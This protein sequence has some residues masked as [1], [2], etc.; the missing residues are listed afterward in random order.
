MQ[1]H[2]SREAL[3]IQTILSPFRRGIYILVCLCISSLV[4]SAAD[5]GSFVSGVP[6]PTN[7]PLVANGRSAPIIASD[8]DYPGVLRAVASLQEDIFRVTG[9]RPSY[10]NN[11]NTLQS[12]VVIIGTIGKNAII[13]GL[14]K[15]KKLN[16]SAVS[17]KWE[18]SVTQVINNPLP[19]VAK[20]LVIAGSDKRGTIFGIYTLS[21][22]IGVSPWYWWADVPVKTQ[23][24]LFVDAGSHVLNEP[25]VKYRGIFLNDEAPALS[26]WAKEKFG[27]L[28]H[29]FYEKVFELLLRLKGNYLWPAMWGNAFNDDDKLNPALADEYGIVMG[30]SHHEPMQRAQ[31]EWKRYGKGEWNYQNN[32]TT[33]RSFWRQGIRNM[34]KHES[35]VT[36]G[37]RG[38]GDEPMSESSNIKLLEK[39]V[40]DQREI[41]S[42]VTGKSSTETPQLWAL[43]KEVQDYYDKGMRV[44]GDIT[45]L[46]CDDNWGNIRKL[47]KVN[48]PA[49]KGGY[50]IY[51]HFD[52]VGGPR[53]Y[54]WLNT[55]SIQKVWEQMHLAS[56][57]GAN[58]IWIVNVGDLKPMEFPTEFFLDYAWNP[59]KWPA[60][61][62]QEYTRLWASKQFGSK[63]ATEIAEILTLYARYNGRR[64]PE[65][66][67]ANTYSLVNFKEFET[68][69]ADYHKLAAKAE[70][71]GNSLPKS[72]QD[73]YF[74][75]IL[76][77]VQACAN[78]N[79]LYF[80][81]AKNRLYAAQGRAETND[82]ALK[83]KELFKRD[84]ILSWKYNHE[85]AGGKWNH[86]MD[87]TH[88][89][90]TNW[91]QPDKDVMPDVRTITLGEVG[92][93]G[94][95]TEGSNKLLEQ[96]YVQ[97][98]A[99]GFNVHEQ[100]HYLDLF[101][102]G[103]KP[104][105]FSIEC[106]VPWLKPDVKTGNIL[107]GTRVTLNA[108]WTKVPVGNTKVTVVIHAD[109]DRYSISYNVVKYPNHIEQAPGLLPVGS[110]VSIE[111]DQFKRVVNAAGV[112]WK[113]LPGH[114][115]TRSGVTAFP[116]HVKPA[117]INANTA[118]L[119]YDIL[120]QDSATVN[121]SAYLSPTLDFTGG[122]GLSYAISFDGE[123]PQVVKMTNNIS[124]RAWEKSVAENI[125]VQVTKHHLNKGKH[126]L[127]FWRV[128]P[129]VVLQKLVISD[130]VLPTS[131]LGPPANYALSTPK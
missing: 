15:S 10:S 114:G 85:I 100:S 14:I 46:L 123:K 34:G 44:P 57:Y 43:Y 84:S 59:D 42:D 5:N 105:K 9:N 62:L 68:V 31:Q 71:V 27:G 121:V 41:I 89:S 51:Y 45:L 98:S 12:Y 110:Y 60:D 7:F 76:H 38:D 130:G 118:H 74:Q 32:D 73:A 2:T 1:V 117:I 30:T 40:K 52:Y 69:V 108:N 111:A 94:V 96:G 77:P 116:V 86:M 91:Q 79:E 36:I 88:I 87:Q 35:I 25:I 75:L 103:K 112:S 131:Y 24:N 83:A 128:D 13:D 64:K 17:N 122:S 99:L 55:N 49:R 23:K 66:L 33:L 107:Q 4:V 67:S 70:R 48:E 39:I 72:Y 58:R 80:T 47:P 106:S 3:F 53:N 18:A 19:G 54:K 21:G 81:V 115:R 93:L 82:L 11:V 56:E 22:Q 78:L 26:Q 28:N 97:A 113:V 20:A 101:N 119:E 29:Q 50:G 120:L 16:V 95:A 102:R 37:M 125:Q 63:Q 61:R 124:M 109:I 65:M 126:V 127:K 90:Y 92:E 6:S 8:G 129:G 104:V